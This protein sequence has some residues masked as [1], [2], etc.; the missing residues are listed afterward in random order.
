M[1]AVPNGATQWR[2]MKFFLTLKKFNFSY[3]CDLLFGLYQSSLYFLTTTFQGWFFP[4][5]QVKSTLLK[6]I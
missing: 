3:Y 1:Q 5:H 4:R 6:K 2:F